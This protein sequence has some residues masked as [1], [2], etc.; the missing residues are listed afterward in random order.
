[1]ETPILAAHAVVDAPPKQAREWF[2]SLKERPE[3]YQFDTHQ[4]FEFVE[5]GFGEIGAQFKTREEFL[6][7]KLELLFELTAVRE[8]GFSFRPIHPVSMGIWGRFRSEEVGEARTRLSLEI[9]SDRCAGRMMLRFFPV[10]RAIQRQI[11]NEVS[12]IK[13][14]IERMP[15]S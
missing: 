1:M 7:L 10:A 4:G 14:S 3:R 9:G 12:H 13:T 15:G 2:L 8:S 6:F 5:G 11:S